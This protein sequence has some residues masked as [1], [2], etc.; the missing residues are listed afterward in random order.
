MGQKTVK[1]IVAAVLTAAAL[2][3]TSVGVFAGYTDATVKSYEEQIIV[4]TRNLEAAQASLSDIRDRR[5]SA[6]EEIARIDEI[7]NTQLELKELT[8]KYLDDSIRNDVSRLLYIKMNTPEVGTG[9]R[10]DSLNEYITQSFSEIESEVKA[11]VLEP[12]NGWEELNR[13][14]LELTEGNF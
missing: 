8:E 11:L 10:I 7:I 3:T 4:A 12:Q 2:L 9:K 14:F 6:W 13:V 5:A 1:R